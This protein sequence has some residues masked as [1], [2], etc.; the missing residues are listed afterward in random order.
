MDIGKPPL[1][2]TDKL[3]PLPY[4]G[5]VVRMPWTIKMLSGEKFVLLEYRQSNAAPF[6]RNP[7]SYT[8][9]ELLTQYG[10][11]LRLVEPKFYENGPLGFALEDALVSIFV[12]RRPKLWN[13]L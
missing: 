9:P 1:L 2:P 10:N 13:F 8:P 4:E 6:T 7:V 5:Q 3:I 11:T 12:Y